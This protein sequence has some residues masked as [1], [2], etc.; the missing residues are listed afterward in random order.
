MANLS[1]SQLET[2]YFN[3]VHWRD[4]ECNGMATMSVHEFYSKFGLENPCKPSVC[5]L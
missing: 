3:F 4:T 2:L 1:E 5:D